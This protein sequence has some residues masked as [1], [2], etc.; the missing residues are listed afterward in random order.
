MNKRTSSILKKAL[1]EVEYE[2]IVLFGSQARGTASEL[3]DY[4]L[5][6][7]LKEDLPFSEKM[8]LS[9]KL[10]RNL[11]QLGID[12]DIILKSQT[13][14]SYYQDKIGHVVRHALQE[15]IILG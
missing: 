11:A 14:V 15:G 3:S 8:R 2:R 6:I 13:E 7:I 9:A 5:L 4:D 1:Q 10:R 12:A